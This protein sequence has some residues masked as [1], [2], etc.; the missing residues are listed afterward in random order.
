MTST[1][2]LAISAADVRAGRWP[3]QY[4]KCIGSNGE[5]FRLDSSCIAED[6]TG[7]RKVR[8]VCHVEF[9]ES[10][11]Q[12][13]AGMGE[14][15]WL[16][17]S[18][19]EGGSGRSMMYTLFGQGVA[20]SFRDRPV[21]AGRDDSETLV[22]SARAIAQGKW[23]PGLTGRAGRDCRCIMRDLV[24][25][26]KVRRISY[27]EL[28]ASGEQPIVEPGEVVCTRRLRRSE[29]FSGVG[30]VAYTWLGDGVRFRIG[31]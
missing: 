2:S 23:P 3:V 27:R 19:P 24:G 14:V 18:Q 9:K 16:R 25:V 20:F 29:G 4:P 8:K 21:N 7:V 30:T 31:G 12:P 17:R 6:F 1:T 11:R 22:I 26:R 5:G 13:V 10:G 15:V 28:L